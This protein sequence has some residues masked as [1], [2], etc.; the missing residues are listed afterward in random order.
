MEHEAFVPFPVGV[1]RRALGEP[2]RVVRCVSAVQRDADAPEGTISGRLRLRIANSTITYRG[3][4]RIAECDG[5][6]EIEGE[7]SESRG[8]GVVKVALVIGLEREDQG[9]R[10][11]F[12]GAVQAGGR[13]AGYDAATAEAAARRLLDRFVNDFITDLDAEPVTGVVDEPP[14]P[15]SGA[16]PPP[17]RADLDASDAM[18]DLYAGEQPV[19]PEEDADDAP[20]PGPYG[21]GEDEEGGL[22]EDDVGI[23]VPETVAGLEDDAAEEPPAEAAHAR[24]TMIGRSA[25]EVDHAPPRGRYAPVAAPDTTSPTDTLRWA[26]PAA[27]ALLAGAV[28]VGRAWRKRR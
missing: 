1:V 7:G 22:D 12:S 6:F 3:T 14:A 25:E 20:D 8:D 28:V 10:L 5:G 19:D 18:D 21:S 17:G 27:A 16:V 13:L 24:R 15:A 23:D 2:D 26:A 4:L 11:E 9:T